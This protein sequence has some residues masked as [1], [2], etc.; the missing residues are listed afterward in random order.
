MTYDVAIEQRDISKINKL[1]KLRNLETFW[2]DA[3]KL[4]RAV[5]SDHA[6]HRWQCL[7]EIRFNELKC[8]KLNDFNYFRNSLRSEIG[9][10]TMDLVD[11]YIKGMGRL[12]TYDLSSSNIDDANYLRRLYI[13]LNSLG[14]M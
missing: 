6:I 8:E 1:N 3:C 10:S 13:T 9:S 5:K 11:D 7:A 4:T 12:P 14:L 2:T